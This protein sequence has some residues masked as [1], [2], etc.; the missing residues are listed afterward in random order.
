MTDKE[1]AR[2]LAVSWR[3]VA[4]QR[5]RWAAAGGGRPGTAAS[6]EPA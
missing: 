5:S 3:T 4:T 1:I 2:R 6:D